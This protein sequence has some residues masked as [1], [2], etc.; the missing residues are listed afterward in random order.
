[1]CGVNAARDRLCV[2]A[3]WPQMSMPIRVGLPTARPVPRL[4]NQNITFS[5]EVVGNSPAPSTG[6]W[7]R[8]PIKSSPAGHDGREVP[9]SGEKS[10]EPVLLLSD[11]AAN[12]LIGVA[13]HHDAGP[14][15]HAEQPD[16]HRKEKRGGNSPTDLEKRLAPASQSTMPGGSCMVAP[17][18]T[19]TCFWA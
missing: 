15:P 4:W 3:N 10:R 18:V 7:I 2:Y 1:M 19:K 17:P 6:R 5:H 8:G 12:V 11:K 13:G 9:P 14:A 16:N